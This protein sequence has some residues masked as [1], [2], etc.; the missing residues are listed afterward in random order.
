MYFFTATI[1]NWQMLLSDDAMKDILIASLK[2]HHRNNRARTHGFVIMPIHIHLLWS[3]A[4]RF[5]DDGNE[6]S[7][8]SF[9]AHEFKKYLMKHHPKRLA[10]YISTEADRQYHF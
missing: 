1:N 8:L 7:L 10:Q 6:Q 3:P 9:T 4:L 2:W 5:Y